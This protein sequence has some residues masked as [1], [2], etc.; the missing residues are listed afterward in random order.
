[1]HWVVVFD[2]NILLSALLSP[3]GSPYHCLAPARLGM[4]E[5]VTCPEIRAELSIYGLLI[6][7]SHRI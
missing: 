4:I 6:S 1:M 3:R 2:T 5:S 7:F